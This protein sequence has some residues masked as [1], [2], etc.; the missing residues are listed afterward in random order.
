MAATTPSTSSDRPMGELD[1]GVVHAITTSTPISTSG[2]IA[3]ARQRSTRKAFAVNH[4]FRVSTSGASIPG[5][6][7]ADGRERKLSNLYLTLTRAGGS[8]CR[9]LG[10]VPNRR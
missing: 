9:Y 7:I 5:F 10:Y 2:T 3:I 6:S 1:R 8:D 4:R